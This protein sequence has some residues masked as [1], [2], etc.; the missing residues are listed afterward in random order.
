MSSGLA[1][2]SAAHSSRCKWRR[3]HKSTPCSGYLRFTS[4]IGILRTRL[5][6]GGNKSRC[7]TYRPTREVSDSTQVSQEEIAHEDQQ[8]VYCL[9]AAQ[10]LLFERGARIEWSAVVHRRAGGA[11]QSR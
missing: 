4:V 1:A 11:R 8:S 5:C 6:S 2:C 3:S 9:T 7:R 10:T